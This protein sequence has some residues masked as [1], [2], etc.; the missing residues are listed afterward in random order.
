MNGGGIGTYGRV[1][2]DHEKVKVAWRLKCWLEMQLASSV[3]QNQPQKYIINHPGKRPT[4][5]IQP[6]RSGYVRPVID[7]HCQTLLSR[8][9]SY[10]EWKRSR[11]VRVQRMGVKHCQETGGKRLIRLEYLAL[12][13][14][15]S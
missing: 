9:E 10:G 7:R 2:K 13:W 1:R 12:E 5:T 4:N 3:A 15:Q 14:V 11:R 6:K 8:R